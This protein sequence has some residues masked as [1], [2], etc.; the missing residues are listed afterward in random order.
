M[1]GWSNLLR[2]LKHSTDKP[3][4]AVI[5]G[6]IPKWLSGTLFRNG[7]GRFEFGDQSYKHV[8]DGS[9]CVHK[10]QINNGNCMYSNKLLETKSYNKMVKENKLLPAFGTDNIDISLFGRLKSFVNPPDHQ[11]NVNVNVV[12]YANNQLYAL[13]EVLLFINFICELFLKTFFFR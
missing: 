13:T 9:A 4:E 10:F 2:S 8:F 3:V 1:T 6:E 5:K 12:P 11:D 7:P